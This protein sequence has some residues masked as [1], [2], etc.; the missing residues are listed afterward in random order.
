MKKIVIPHFTLIICE[1]LS[2]LK[3]RLLP[4]LEYN[5]INKFLGRVSGR[6]VD[7]PLTQIGQ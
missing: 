3:N 4:L 7:C 6:H 5:N 1:F 2:K